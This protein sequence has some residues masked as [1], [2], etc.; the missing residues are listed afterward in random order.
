MLGFALIFSPHIA[1][2][3]HPL[4]RRADVEQLLPRDP[5]R[6]D[7][8]HR[9]RDR[10]EPRRGGARPASRTSRARSRCV[11]VAVFAIYF[12][13]PLIALSALP[14]TK[15]ADGELPDAARRSGPPGGFTNDPVLGLVENLGL[16]GAVLSALEDLRRHPRGDDPLHRHERGRDRRV[17]D[18]VRDGELPAAARGLPPAAPEVQDAVALAARLRRRDLD[19]RPAPGQDGLPRDDVLVRRDALVHDRA[20]LGDRAARQEPRRRSSSTGRGRT[21]ASAASTGRCSR[22][23]AGSAPALA[24]LVVVVQ[25][26]GDALGGPRLARRR[27]H[28]LRRLPARRAAR[29]ADARR[30]ARRSS[31]GPAVALEYRNILVPVVRRRRVGGGD[32]PRLPPR[33]RARRDDRRADA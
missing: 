15:T 6:D 17:A 4:G 19:P 22:S 5:G 31:L 14:V 9:D 28:H 29:A 3:E 21:C 2:L 10:L 7:R 8:L 23:S 24:W 26:A 25:E 12:T 13:L 16:H 20:R 32:R 18:H 33:H 30:C 1:V 11:A 27:V